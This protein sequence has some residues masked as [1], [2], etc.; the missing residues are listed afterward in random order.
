M[1]GAMAKVALARHAVHGDFDTPVNF[2][3]RRDLLRHS[4]SLP[5]PERHCVKFLF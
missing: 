4:L 2:L 5:A 3:I 1:T